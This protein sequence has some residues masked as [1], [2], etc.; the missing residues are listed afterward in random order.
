M[1][2]DRTK[3]A[4]EAGVDI[5]QVVDWIAVDPDFAE[6]IQAIE[7]GNPRHDLVCSLRLAQLQEAMAL[8]GVRRMEVRI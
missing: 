7:S 6:Q 8:V 4:A 1:N 2:R 5:A 3:A